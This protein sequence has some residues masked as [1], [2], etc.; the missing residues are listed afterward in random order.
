MS[1]LELK[2]VLRRVNYEDSPKKRRYRHAVLREH[3]MT[4]KLAETT[5]QDSRG[6]RHRMEGSL[7]EVRGVISKFRDNSQDY[8]D[9]C[10]KFAL[11]IKDD[12]HLQTIKEAEKDLAVNIEKVKPTPKSKISEKFTQACLSKKAS[13]YVPFAPVAPMKY[14]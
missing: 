4:R 1:L 14:N 13:K 5:L 7:E 11:R 12:E 10:E 3:T 8:Q 2:T 9:A 6:S